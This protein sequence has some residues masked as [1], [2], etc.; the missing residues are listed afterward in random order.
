MSLLLS[1]AG[2]AGDLATSAVKRQHGVKDFGNLL[3]PQGGM[4][5]R[6]DSLLAAGG[7]FHLLLSGFG[8]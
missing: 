6:V 2:V 4:V 7:V 3:G 1:V 5:D 8:V